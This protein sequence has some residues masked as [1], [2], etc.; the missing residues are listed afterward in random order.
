MLRALALKAHER[1]DLEQCL[2][3]IEAKL[4]VEEGSLVVA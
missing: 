2:T 3:A 1:Q 4:K